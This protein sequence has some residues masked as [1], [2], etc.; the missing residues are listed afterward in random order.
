MKGSTVGLSSSWVLVTSW[1]KEGM[2]MAF[3]WDHH[4][5]EEG[6]SPLSLTLENTLV[7]TDPTMGWHYSPNAFH[8]SCS[9][10]L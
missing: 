4:R 2:A 10:C 9:D 6:L 7:P 8:L 3:T 1:W 5:L